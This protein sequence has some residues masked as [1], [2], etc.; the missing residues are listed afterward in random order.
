MSDYFR[1][2]S[3]YIWLLYGQTAMLQFYKIS[4][5]LVQVASPPPLPRMPMTHMRQPTSDFQL[6]FPRAQF[7]SKNTA[8]PQHTLPT[9]RWQKMLWQPHSSGRMNFSF[10]RLSI[11]LFKIKPNGMND[12]PQPRL[13]SAY[14]NCQGEFS[15][16]G[17]R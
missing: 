13:A 4:S 8:P 2:C 12:F 11:F 17:N 10:T 6:N 14:Y 1:Q 15:L 7:A 9:Q 16:T 3:I 5:A